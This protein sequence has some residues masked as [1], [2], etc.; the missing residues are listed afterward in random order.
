MHV[1]SLGSLVVA[2]GYWFLLSKLTLQLQILVQA[3]SFLSIGVCNATFILSWY[4][5]NF[6]QISF[7]SIQ[8]P[9]VGTASFML[10]NQ[11][12][13]LIS[14]ANYSELDESVDRL[15]PTHNGDIIKHRESLARRPSAGSCSGDSGSESMVEVNTEGTGAC[16]GI[17]VNSISSVQSYGLMVGEFGDE[18]TLPVGG[19]ATQ[20]MEA[21]QDKGKEKVS[22]LPSLTSYWQSI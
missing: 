8:S 7:P 5:G 1:V 18:M 2:Q 21:F 22:L 10:A 3:S 4:T 20:Q 15:D 6:L 11:R 16:V 13:V 17:H 9:A 19:G 12:P 14:P